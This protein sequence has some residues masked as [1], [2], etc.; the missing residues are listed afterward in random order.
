M[1]SGETDGVEIDR[2]IV[3]NTGNPDIPEFLCGIPELLGASG[4]TTSVLVCPNSEALILYALWEQYVDKSSNQQCRKR[5]IDVLPD[6]GE[7]KNVW[8]F[9]SASQSNNEKFLGRGRMLVEKVDLGKNTGIVQLENGLCF[10]C[11]ADSGRTK[12]HAAKLLFARPCSTYATI[13]PNKY[14]TVKFPIHDYYFPKEGYRE[15]GI[16]SFYEFLG[17]HL[18]SVTAINHILREILELDLVGGRIDTAYS[19]SDESGLVQ[20]ENQYSQ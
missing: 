19:M 2:R 12:Y 6:R 3:I 5:K 4:K 1:L 16:A 18:N 13:D 8:Y 7:I 17:R 9:A 10:V 20:I 11:I 14:R 15:E